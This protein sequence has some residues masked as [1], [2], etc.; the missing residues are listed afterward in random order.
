MKYIV[1]CPYFGK[2]PAHVNLWLKSCSYNKSFEFVV[3]TDDCIEDII[4]VNVK[5]IKMTFEQFK[6]VIQRKF[7][8][9]IALDNP[10][11]LCD[12]K[13]TYG[14]VF[15]EDILNYDYWGYCDVDLIF[16]DLE[17]FMP[18]KIYDKISY[19]GHLTLYRND[20]NINHCFK[21]CDKGV[22]SYRDILGSN[23]HFGYDE[24]GEYGINSKFISK[25]Y[26]IYHL[27]QSIADI[28]C[29]NKNM[30]LT[31][32]KNN[33]F[34]HIKG[35]R[36]FSF[37]EGKIYSWTLSQSKE[38]E[39]QEY[40]YIHF[41]KRKMICNIKNVDKFLVL[42][43]K[44]INYM[45]INEKIIKDSQEKGVYLLSVKIKIKAF[46]HLL[47]RIII[48]IKIKH[49]NKIDKFDVNKQ[50]IVKK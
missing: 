21:Q 22:L 43:H 12:F 28:Y 37:E 2:L 38:I 33:D 46:F 9:P 3:I 8:F 30:T 7:E 10:Y 20:I 24:I 11:K 6:K 14:Y 31:Y 35:K 40:A 49:T 34:M 15:E 17:K 45:D 50:K 41:Q 39:K 29:Y 27:E 42:P 32:K 47:H 1:F 26:T 44:F 16:G 48:I 5:Y 18:D 25:G 23:M 19:L 4:P 36:I 13:P